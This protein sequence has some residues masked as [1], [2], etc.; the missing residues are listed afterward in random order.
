MVLDESNGVGLDFYQLHE[1]I[2]RRILILREQGLDGT[3]ICQT[4]DIDPEALKQ[5]MRGLRNGKIKMPENLHS[6][7]KGSSF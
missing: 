1:N 2:I 4:L 5:T 3:E 6:Q 7:Q